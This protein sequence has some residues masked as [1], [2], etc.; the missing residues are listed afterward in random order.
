MRCVG[1][2]CMED[3][4]GMYHYFRKIADSLLGMN[5]QVHSVL[6]RT[7]GSK[8]DLPRHPNHIVH[9]VN[10]SLGFVDKV[11][12]KR[13]DNAISDIILQTSV[14]TWLILWDS[15]FLVRVPR[16]GN[17]RFVYVVHDVFPHEAQGLKRIA[18]TVLYRRSLKKR[19]SFAVIATNSIF[20]YKLLNELL[21]DG[22]KVFYFPMPS[23]VTQEIES[24]K[25]KVPEV[26]R[27]SDYFLF[28]G[29][30][31]PYKGVQTLLRAFSYYRGSRELV[32][33][34]R[35]NLK[36]PPEVLRQNRIVLINRFIED[37]EIRDLFEKA[38]CVVFPY[39][40][41]TQ[42]GPIS[43]AYYFKKPVIISGIPPLLEKFNVAAPEG[44]VVSAGDV[45]ALAYALELMDQEDIRRLFEKNCESAY[46]RYYNETYLSQRL[47]ELLAEVMQS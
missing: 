46:L 41:A 8:S 20:Q 39:K 47:E 27:L 24:G 11:F 23:S 6:L 25:K 7:R 45:H 34:G 31:E 19:K 1:L 21:R 13:V 28:F 22:K 2:I 37:E 40:T 30:I 15:Y 29:R 43:I 16:F 14:N 38:C 3:K 12:P 17:L 9:Y 5:Y 26:A 32:I 42:V 10:T 44:I 4:G 33:A 36:M 18:T 35:G